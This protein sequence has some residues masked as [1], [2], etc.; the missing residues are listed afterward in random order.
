MIMTCSIELSNDQFA[1]IPVFHF[2]SFLGSQIE[3][4]I[5]KFLNVKVRNYY[6]CLCDT[7]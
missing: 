6:F 3:L 4:N 7:H 2:D 5:D 1:I